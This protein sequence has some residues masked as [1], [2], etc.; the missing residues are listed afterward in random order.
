MV[1]TS[2]QEQIEL[3][4]NLWKRYGLPLIIGV[5]IASLV[6]FAWRYWLQLQ[7]QKINQASVLYEQTLINLQNDN[8][9][10]AIASAQLI[11]KSYSRT[12]YAAPAAL[13]LAKIAVNQQKFS[14]AITDL[15]WAIDHTKI[16]AL[17]EVA[18]IREARVLVQ[19]QQYQ[20]ALTLL[21]SLQDKNYVA[22]SEE[23]K[24]DIYSALN[25]PQEA[26]NAYQLA[27]N[28]LPDKGLNNPLLVMKLEN[29]GVDVS[30]PQKSTVG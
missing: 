13:L 15:K 22:V 4:K 26:K 14:Q 20:P 24:G 8:N 1:Y 27:L 19:M 2:E 16:T 10:D 7:H 25:Q 21:N 28:A 18:I 5:A 17:K 11:Q 3:V 12:A 9:P 23:I 6:T 30:F 29:Y